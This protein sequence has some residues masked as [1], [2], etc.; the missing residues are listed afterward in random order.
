MYKVEDIKIIPYVR[1]QT[2]DGALHDTMDKALAHRPPHCKPGQY[3]MWGREGDRYSHT[4]EYGE[5][6]LVFISNAEAVSEF[7][8]DCEWNSS[9][10]DG[11]SG[12]GWYVWDYQERTWM[13][14]P[15]YVGENLVKE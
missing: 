1:F 5:A 11:V 9:S 7:E 12:P 15:D 10:S 13:P 4:D 14:L 3:V 8:N 6:I 2:P